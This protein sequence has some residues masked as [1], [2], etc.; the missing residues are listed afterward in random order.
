MAPNDARD[1]LILLEQNRLH[2]NAS[3]AIRYAQI[4]MALR[5]DAAVAERSAE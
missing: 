2:L 3:E 1:L 5:Q 4:I